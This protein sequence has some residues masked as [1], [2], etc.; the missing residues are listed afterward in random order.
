[1][2]SSVLDVIDLEGR[3]Q[4]DEIRVGGFDLIHA[5]GSPSASITCVGDGSHFYTTALGAE[6]P[7]QKVDRMPR[8]PE[9]NLPPSGAGGGNGGEASRRHSSSFST[10]GVGLAGGDGGGGG[11]GSASPARVGGRGSCVGAGSSS[12]SAGS[13]STK[14]SS[15]LA[16]GIRTGSSDSLS[17]DSRGQGRSGRTETGARGSSRGGE[18][19]S[20]GSGSCINSGGGNKGGGGAKG[21]RSGEGDRE[22]NAKDSSG[23]H[24]EKKT[25]KSP[26]RAVE[27]GASRSLPPPS[28]RSSSSES[29]RLLTVP[30]RKGI[31]SS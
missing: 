7:Q 9:T 3:N 15:P 22:R 13:G 18:R 28:R 16:R 14:S 21:I 12:G 20:G 2:L 29:E 30:I 8:N 26:T 10:G 4:G 27:D 11:G 17:R 25:G 31:H 19:S 5:G 24:R 6:I 1:M 23:R